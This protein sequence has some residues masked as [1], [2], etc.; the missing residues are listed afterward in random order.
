MASEVGVVDVDP[1]EVLQKGRLKPGRMLLCDVVR[2][3]LT[4]DNDIKHEICSSRPATEWLRKFT[5][6]EDLHEIYKSVN[7]NFE[8]VMNS[9]MVRL[10]KGQTTKAKFNKSDI[11]LVE[12]DRRL[13]LFGYNIETLSMLL[14]PMISNRKES[15]GSMGNDAPLACLSMQNPMVYDY[16]KQLFAQVTNPPIDPIREKCVMSL[17]CPIGPE[18]NL[19]EPS[20]NDCERLWLSQP[21][22]SLEDLFVLKNIEYRNFKVRLA[23]TEMTN[24][25]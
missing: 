18:A 5:R 23:H 17:A 25:F 7:P 11:F 22:L 14:L 9:S 4:S 15:L 13:P 12:E 16:F 20:A 8:E 6:I 3:E 19:L 2:K 1:S 21:I 10:A 24:R